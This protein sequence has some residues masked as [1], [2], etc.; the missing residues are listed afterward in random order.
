MILTSSDEDRDLVDSYKL[1][2]NSYVRKPVDFA[3]FAEA[4]RQLELYWLVINHPP[5]IDRS[6]LMNKTPRV[7]IVEDSEDD[8]LLVLR[9]LRKGGYEPAAFDRGVHCGGHA[10][11]TPSPPMGPHCCGLRNAR[12][13]RNGRAGSN[14]R[15]RA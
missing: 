5:P 4:V 15:D 12:V 1:G 13:Q 7:L 9:E 2:A 6:G 3:Q 10:G 14:G 11:Q 8:A